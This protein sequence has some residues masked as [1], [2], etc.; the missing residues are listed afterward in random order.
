MVYSKRGAENGELILF[1]I[2]NIAFFSLMI[3]F[4]TKNTDNALIYEQTYSKKI[5]FFLDSAKPGMIIS[6]QAKDLLEV[7]KKKG[8]NLSKVIVIDSNKVY[9][10]LDNAGGYSSRYFSSYDIQIKRD[11]S[12]GDTLIFEVK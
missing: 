4:I 1:I 7:A 10:N 12:S 8:V 6:I 2:L 11:L 3:L 9:V 5:A